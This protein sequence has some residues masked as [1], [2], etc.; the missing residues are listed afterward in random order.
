[1]MARQLSVE[2]KAMAGG[3][4]LDEFQ[5]SAECGENAQAHQQ[6]EQAQGAHIRTPAYL[7]S[8]LGHPVA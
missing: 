3:G 6:G 4:I 2:A 7:I 8:R 5:L 1:M